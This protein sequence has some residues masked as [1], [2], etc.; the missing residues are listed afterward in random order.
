M[1]SQPSLPGFD[2]EPVAEDRL[3]FAIFPDADTAQ[4]IAQLAGCLSKAHEVKGKILPAERFH[5]S[6]HHLG[7]YAGVPRD[8]LAMAAKAAA[9]V[10]GKMLPFG[11]A[12]DR[13]MSF[14]GSPGHHP[15]VLR[16]SD[17]LVPLAAFHQALGIELARAGFKFRKSHYTPH[18]TLLYGDRLIAEQAIEAISWTVRELVLVHSLI[19]REH[20][21]PYVPLARWTLSS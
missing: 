3:F 10:S 17:G 21:E 8:I 18:L 19:N 12:F 16:G 14:R 11:I 6:L 4:S 2:P 15:F 20:L 7:D 5:I 9:A 1:H 13:A